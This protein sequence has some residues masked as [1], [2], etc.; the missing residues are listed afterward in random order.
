MKKLLTVAGSL[1]FAVFTA[2]AGC[3]DPRANV[4]ALKERDVVLEGPLSIESVEKEHMIMLTIGGQNKSIAFGRE[5]TQWQK[6]KAH[7]DTGARLY[8]ISSSE[9][10]WSK[11]LSGAFKG[12]GAIQSGCLVEAIITLKN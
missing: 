3:E 5:N 4:Q 12:Y 6:V 2:H 9:E 11:P 10:Q 7:L 8:S 1:L